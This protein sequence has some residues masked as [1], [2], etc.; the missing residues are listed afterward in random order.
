MAINSINTNSNGTGLVGAGKQNP[1]EFNRE[2]KFAQITIPMP[3]TVPLTGAE[4]GFGRSKPKTSSIDYRPRNLPQVKYLLTEKSIRESM[5]KYPNPAKANDVL[6]KSMKEWYN[7]PVS[8]KTLGLRKTV[9]NYVL[10]ADA[11][12]KSA[13]SAAIP[14]QISSDPSKE[15]IEQAYE[16]EDRIF[17]HRAITSSEVNSGIECK[18]T[19][20]N[21]SSAWNEYA[22]KTATTVGGLKFGRFYIPLPVWTHG[23]GTRPHLGSMS[24]NGFGAVSAT[25][26]IIP[27]IGRD[28]IFRGV[29]ELPTGE[30]VQSILVDTTK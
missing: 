30:K 3:V 27:S 6:I 22:S 12:H 11:S 20:V 19:V 16:L 1:A 29:C 4:G 15:L 7:D 10:M 5:Q 25:V 17:R 8:K 23:Y 24:A 2:V 9:R 26:H 18:T 14:T 28:A 21:S 13:K